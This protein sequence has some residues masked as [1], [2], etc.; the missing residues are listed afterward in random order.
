[1]ATTPT[2]PVGATAPEAPVEVK[3]PIDGS[4][5]SAL[6][7]VEVAALEKREM[8]LAP[9]VATLPVEM[10]VSVPVREFRV[11]NLLTLEPGQIIETD[12]G[13]GDDVPLAAGNVRLT[14]SEFEVVESQLAVRITRLS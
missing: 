2:V 12:W 1:M 7:P 3:Q 11:R 10:D 6:V 8:A 5:E 13:H 9:P 14:W 4:S